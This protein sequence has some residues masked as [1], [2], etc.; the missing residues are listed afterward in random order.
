MQASYAGADQ[1][2][3]HCKARL[4]SVVGR[5]VCRHY[6]ISRETKLLAVILN[7]DCRC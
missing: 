5:D 4:H 1:E 2:R 7:P 6:S 3:P